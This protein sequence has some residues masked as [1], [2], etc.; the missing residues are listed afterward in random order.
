MNKMKAWKIIR[1]GGIKSLEDYF[2]EDSPDKIESRF[3]GDYFRA[4]G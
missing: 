3:F 4:D 1:D 2:G